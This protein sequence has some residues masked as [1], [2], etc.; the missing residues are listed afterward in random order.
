[1]F[2]FKRSGGFDLENNE[3]RQGE[4]LPNDSKA[5][6]MLKDNVNNNSLSSDVKSE[7]DECKDSIKNLIPDEPN[8]NIVQENTDPDTIIEAANKKAEEPLKDAKI[9]LIYLYIECEENR[10]KQQAPLIKAIAKMTKTLI[11]LFNVIIF[12]VSISAIAF[13]FIFE[14]KGMIDTL[15]TFL[16]YYI[17][18]VVVELL[19]MILYIVKSI[20]SNSSHT[21]L[22]D[23]IIKSDT[24]DN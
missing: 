3:E 13:C 19:G 2:L 5:E 9:K 8:I 20:F 18:A 12:L 16:K 10:V 22:I 17:G 4:N 24:K 1:M 15:L 23:S 21:A 7:Y 11:W 14:E 6:T